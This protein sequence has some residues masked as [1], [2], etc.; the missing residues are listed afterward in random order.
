MCCYILLILLELFDSI[1]IFL[2]KGFYNN[3]RTFFSTPIKFLRD[4]LNHPLTLP[5][6]IFHI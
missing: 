5:V 2:M 1:S 4:I 3:S 6:F